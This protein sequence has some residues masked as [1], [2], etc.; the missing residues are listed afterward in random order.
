MST[1]IFDKNWKHVDTLKTGGFGRGVDFSEE[2][3]RVYIGLSATRKRY[4]KVIPTTKYHSNR[5]FITTIDDRK[6]L[7][8]IPIPNIEQLDN[9]YILNEKIK[10]IFEGLDTFTN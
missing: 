6:E 7:D 3:N 2:E 5:I 1:K 8:Q 4:L 9:V 10:T